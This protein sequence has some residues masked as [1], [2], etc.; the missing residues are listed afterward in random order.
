VDIRINAGLGE[1]RLAS[2][3]FEFGDGKYH[4]IMVTK[5]GK[6][7]ELRI[8]D[9]LHAFS[10]L[11][12]GSN[13]VKAPGVAG[14]LFLGGLPI[15]INTTGKAVSSVPLIGTIKDAIFNDQL[16]YFDSP[17]EFV[18]AAIGQVG[19]VPQKDNNVYSEIAS[20]T[21]AEKSVGC[22][23]E[24]SFSLEPGAVKF[25]DNPHSYVLVT[26]GKRHNMQ[27]N[28]KMD[29][30][31]RSFYPNGL[32]F[33][34]IG[35][36][37]KQNNYLMMH[38]YNGRVQL[39]LKTR[40]RVEISTQAVF[41]DGLWHKIQL[42]KENKTLNFAIDSIPQEK[43]NLTKKLSLGN[44]MYV[45]G[46][47]ENDIQ[48][49][50]SLI[51]QAFKGCMQGFSIN[52]QEEELISEKAIRHKVGQC[53]PQVEKGSFFPGDAY[54]IYKNQ[55]YVGA[56]LELSLE[57]RTT[58]TTAVLLSVSEPEGY[59][60]LSLEL[61]QGKVIISGDMGDRRPFRVEQSF[62]S[63]FAICDNKW[64]Q[65][66]AFYVE[67]K[68][69]LKVDQF[70]QKYWLLD[71]GHITG[72]RTNSPLYIGGLPD[73]ASSGTLGT[74]ENFKGCIRNMVIGGE[75]TDWTNMDGLHNILLGSCPLIVH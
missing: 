64:H 3:G 71:N 16:L 56:L 57:L 46:I 30:R 14:G 41:N 10:S 12:E 66:Q 58:Q 47:P 45:G 59:P 34:L 1:V 11:P 53:F 37:G 51:V 38:L 74:R 35:T 72:A 28:F 75:R 40:K 42:V 18:H 25:G 55:F 24:G 39:V 33:T 62:Q 7:L 23:K 19:P 43:L 49:P 48:L 4:S 70:E 5:N 2:E 6:K 52:H 61:N 13:V 15:E 21:S 27:K 22:M 54:A 50:D 9:V 36:R 73:S 67:D 8:D 20:M 26:F 63:E 32:I 17:I 29:F 60:A 31:F 65:I 44:T 69:T 68:L